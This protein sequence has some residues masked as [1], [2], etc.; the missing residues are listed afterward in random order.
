[1]VR[2][3]LDA[4]GKLL[5]FE[6]MPQQR[7][8]PPKTPPAA[9][10]WG[11]LFAAAGLDRSQWQ[12]AEPEWTSLAASDMRAAWTSKDRRIEAASLRGEPVYFEMVEPWMKPNRVP[13][14]AVSSSNA[15]AFAI[16]SIIL[17]VTCASSA[18]LAAGNLRRQRGDRR[19]AFRLAGF[20]AAV[21]MAL[22]LCRSHILISFGTF[23]SF[24]MG[25]CTSIFYGVVM[26]TI[27]L[28]LEPYVRRRW[29][30]TLIS[31]SA[32]LIGRLRDTVVGRDVL[33]GCAGGALIAVIGR[34]ADFGARGLGGWM[35]EMDST[36][37]LDGARGA[38]ALLFTAVPHAIRDSLFFFLIIFLLRAV[39][40]N[41][42]I[43]GAAFALIFA[44]LNLGA[45]HPL[46]SVS[47]S[48][49][50]LFGLAVLLLRWGLLAMVV[51]ML[52]GNV[53]S[54]PV[55]SGSSWYFAG[56]MFLISAALALAAWAFHVSL[57]GRK[58]W[59]EEFLG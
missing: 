47:I 53:S 49:V 6:R 4:R 26:W 41:Q 3:R 7:Q 1:M 11:P 39:L 24:I 10:D 5:S 30:Q 46:F 33:I 31:W 43:A 2:I 32:V 50:V 23:G 13:E 8:A 58:L 15:V 56:S 35:P 36:L 40:R 34:V 57:G 9:P 20:M 22:W 48:F 42:W 37:P 18:I 19:G 12:P 16:L 38:L 21:H 29:P 55:G 17:V 44:S 25:M 45:D 52:L 59:K 14:S 51:T 28:A 27:Y 54:I